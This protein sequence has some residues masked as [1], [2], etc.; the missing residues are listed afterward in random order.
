[1]L[2]LLQTP[3]A[4]R[5]TAETRRPETAMGFL[6]YTGITCDQRCVGAIINFAEAPAGRFATT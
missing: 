6:N 2:G 4:T 3:A 1:M 5:E